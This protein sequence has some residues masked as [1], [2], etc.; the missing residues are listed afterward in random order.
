LITKTK[1]ENLKEELKRNKK[2]LN[3]DNRQR[4]ITQSELITDANLK[5]NEDNNE[6]IVKSK[7]QS[8]KINNIIM[9]THAFNS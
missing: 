6:T 8:N 5:S 2:K 3:Y 4:Q 1:K 7:I 9:V